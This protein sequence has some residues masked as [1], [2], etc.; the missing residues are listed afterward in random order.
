M[1]KTS[2]GFITAFILFLFD[3]SLYIYC[4]ITGYNT[5]GTFGVDLGSNQSIIFSTL[6]FICFCI[7]NKIRK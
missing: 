6:F 5:L 2:K 4:S 3:L 7:Y 1:E